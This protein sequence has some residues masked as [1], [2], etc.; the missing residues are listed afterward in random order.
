MDLQICLIKALF[1]PPLSYHQI[2]LFCRP[3]MPAQYKISKLLLWLN[4]CLGIIS[5]YH[6][7]LM[8]TRKINKTTS[9]T[10]YYF[11]IG[12]EDSHWRYEDRQRHDVELVK[13]SNF[14]LYSIPLFDIEFLMPLP[15]FYISFDLLSLFLFCELVFLLFY[16]YCY[17]PFHYSASMLSSFYFIFFVNSFSLESVT[18]FRQRHIVGYHGLYHSMVYHPLLSTHFNQL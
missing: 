5:C 9:L 7:T 2:I 3:G 15:G 10:Y 4:I 17:W 14:L 6:T 16:S 8:L 1:L 13:L 11:I 12:Y 18:G